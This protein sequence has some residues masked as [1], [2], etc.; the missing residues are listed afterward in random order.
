M[1]QHKKRGQNPISVL[2][3]A[4]CLLLANI[5]LSLSQQRGATEPGTF[6]R[7][8]HRRGLLAEPSERAKVKRFP[9]VAQTPPHRCLYLCGSCIV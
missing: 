4:S 8:Q 5:S 1:L 7:P 9:A 3:L 6:G 2:M